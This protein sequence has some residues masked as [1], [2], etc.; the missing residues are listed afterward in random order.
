MIE[1]RCLYIILLHNKLCRERAEKK[2]RKDNFFLLGK[3]T[4]REKTRYLIVI[5][6]NKMLD[7]TTGQAH[8]RGNWGWWLRG[9]GEHDRMSCESR[10]TIY[11]G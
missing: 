10:V 5:H 9:S 2:K 6:M 7:T 1:N 8:T 3:E 4:R 11:S